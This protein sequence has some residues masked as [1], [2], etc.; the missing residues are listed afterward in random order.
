MQAI[1]EGNLSGILESAELTVIAS[2]LSAAEG[3]VW[4][5]GGFLS[6]VDLKQNK[7][8]RWSAEQGLET[9]RE[10]NRE[11]NGCAIDCQGRMVM[12]ESGTRSIVR[13]ES[14]D[15]WTTIADNWKGKR[16]NR[17]NGIVC[18]SDGTLYFSDPLLNVPPGKRELD[19]SVVWRR[20]PDGSLHVA[21][22]EC[23]FPNCMA[24]SPDEI[25]L[26]VSNSFLDEECFD[27]RK[28]GDT[29]SHRYLAAYDVR[30]DG[31]L[32][33]Y[34]LL[35]DMTSDAHSVPDGLRVDRNGIIFCTGSGATWVIAPSGEV[36]GKIV[37][38]DFTRN[39]AFGD[40]DYCTLFLTALTTVYSLRV[41]APGIGRPQARS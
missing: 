29:C 12:C 41:K 6:F 33:N 34:T 21:A 40:A 7:L 25:V 15:S 9:M 39:C 17:P 2:G 13:L 38:P 32:A 31:S 4:H 3:P 24:L 20:A 30:P 35:V 19:S 11:G 8:L 18:R 37:T 28:R 26:Y 23:G 14:D 5:P 10:P 1:I 16:L 36:L 22:E 27:E